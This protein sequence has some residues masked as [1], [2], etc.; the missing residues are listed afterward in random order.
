MREW[1]KNLRRNKKLSQE[2]VAA[3]FNITQNAYSKLENGDRQADM[4]LSTAAK[5]ADYFDIP[6]SRI[7]YYEEQ[8]QLANEKKGA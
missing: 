4:N 1:L 5:I 3:E 8:L 6:L 7:R 2:E